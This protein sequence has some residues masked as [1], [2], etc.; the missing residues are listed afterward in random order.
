VLDLNAASLAYVDAIGK[1]A[2]EK[3]ALKDGDE[4]HLNA[5]GSIVFGRMVADLLEGHQ[6]SVSSLRR[7]AE[8][9]SCFQKWIQANET[10]SDEI[11]KG[12]A[13]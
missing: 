7:R 1:D 3:Y 13:A 4:T 10:M 8:D 9:P 2:A 11:W 5:W 6:P 12:T